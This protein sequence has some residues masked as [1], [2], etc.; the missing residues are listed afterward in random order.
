MTPAQPPPVG[1]K[2]IVTPHR[3]SVGVD[4]AVD[5]S[6]DV[7]VDVTVDIPVDWVGTPRRVNGHTA[8]SEWARCA[9]MTLKWAP[10][11]EAPFRRGSTQ[12]RLHPDEAPFKIP[13][14]VGSSRTMP[15]PSQS[16]ERSSVRPLAGGLAILSFI[17]LAVTAWMWVYLRREQDLLAD[18]IQHLPPGDLATAR[19]LSGD[20]R[21]Q[22]GL[23]ILLVV[24]LVA[25]AIAILMALRGYVNSQRSLR[26]VRVLS[27]DILASMDAAVITADRDG[28]LTSTNPRGHELVDI[29]GDGIGTPLAM[30]SSDHAL[31]ASIREEVITHHHSVRDRDYVVQ[32]QGHTQTLRAGCTLLRNER[33]E[34]IGTVLH[35]RDVTQKALMEDQMRRMERYM[36]LGSLAAGLQHEIKNPLSA[37]SLHVQLLCERLDA[38][39]DDVAEMLGVLTSEVTRIND[40]LDGFRNYAAQTT[41]GHSVVDVTGIVGKMVRLLRPQAD[42]VDV[43]IDVRLP[44]HPIGTMSGDAV[45]LEQVLLNLALNGLAA[46][47]SGGRLTFRVTPSDDSI[48][49]SVA[50][51]GHGIPLEIRSQIFD[52]YFTTRGD[53]TGM[54]LA[55][56][57]KIVRQHGGS[58]DVR[59]GPD[60]SEFTIVL[61][62]TGDGV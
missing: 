50:D 19:E 43:Q 18:L 25:T 42:S 56:C 7:S 10:S 46:M 55:I 59:T 21:L 17:A 36:G 13:S 45:G 14:R 37:L 52:P 44:E 60:G 4:V 54:G 2:S 12:T 1:L 33:G 9:A 11:D 38:P 28:I 35:V 31:L 57:D 24:N 39:D 49:I 61:P 32:R 58:I 41:I 48:R 3:T 30:L 53:G 23:T 51:T 34:E 29:P 6:V 27:A 5:V 16:T 40:V 8:S 26:D 20:L 47:P 15:F 62:I 22:G